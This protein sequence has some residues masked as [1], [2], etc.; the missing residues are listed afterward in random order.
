M[1]SFL[2]TPKAKIEPPPELPAP[3]QVQPQAQ[4]PPVAPPQPAPATPTETRTAAVAYAI[5]KRGGTWCAVAYKMSPDGRV[6]DEILLGR[7]AREDWGA[8][9]ARDLARDAADKAA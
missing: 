1:M 5:D 3:V 6:L 7:L 8:R 2:K 9:G 4:L